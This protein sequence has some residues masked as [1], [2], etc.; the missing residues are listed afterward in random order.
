[1][2]WLKRLVAVFATAASGLGVAADATYR[3]KLAPF[4]TPPART[5]GLL[6][7]ARINGGPP[8]ELLLDSGAASIVLDAKSAAKSGCSGG[9]DLDLVMP[10][11]PAARAVKELRTETVQV[12]DLMLRDLPVLIAGHRL[13]EG[14]QGVLPLSV[15]GGFLIR[16]DIP[17]K[18]LELQPYPT[19]VAVPAGGIAAISNHRLLFLKGTVDQDREG[20]FLLDTGASYNAI[21]RNVARRM[22]IAEV[23]SPRIPLVGGTEEID[24]PLVGGVQVRFGAQELAMGQVVAI[25]FSTASRFHQLE[26][27]GLLGY[28]ALRDSVLQVSYRDGLVRMDFRQARIRATAYVRAR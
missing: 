12:G 13:A 3:I 11:A 5:V 2:A 17:G 18:S 19:D 10:G 14:I 24:A 21:A 16:L 23:F 28:P 26:V 22:N 20:Y 25:D 7:K 1:M 15:F 4:V 27:A 6:I 9:T 8:L